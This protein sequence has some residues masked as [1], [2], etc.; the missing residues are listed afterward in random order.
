MRSV[1]T[2][3]TAAT[4]AAALVL[5]PAARAGE[6]IPGIDV[7]L[8]QN[9]GGIIVATGTTDKTGKITFAGVPG[10]SYTVII[11]DRTKLPGAVVITMSSPGVAAVTSAPMAPLPAS[12]GSGRGKTSAR[13]YGVA[14][15]GDAL[16]LVLPPVAAPGAPPVGRGQ[17]PVPQQ[18]VPI[19]VTVA[20]DKPAPTVPIGK[21]APP[22][23]PAGKAQ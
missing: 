1:H 6:P 9:P 4:L 10:R 2:L 8:G 22:A 13:G 23:A 5:A 3:L 15:G 11:E 18:S 17:P 20:L 21:A 14:N 19:T 12:Q 16:A 7:N